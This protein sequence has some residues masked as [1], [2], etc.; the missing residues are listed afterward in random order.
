MMKMIG[1]WKPHTCSFFFC[2][3]C[4]FSQLLLSFHHHIGSPF[5]VMHVSSGSRGFSEWAVDKYP[6][7]PPLRSWKAWNEK[8]TS[9][10]FPWIPVKWAP[11]CVVLSLLDVDWLHVC[12]SDPPPVNGGSR[13]ATPHVTT[14]LSSLLTFS[15]CTELIEHIPSRMALVALSRSPWIKGVEAR[16][17]A[18]RG[19]EGPAAPSA[20]H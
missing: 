18:R 4:P 8:H 1:W 11:V 10:H 2:A 19:S 16:S 9:S 3:V 17:Y 13:C 15:C 12:T 20:G 5:A 6:S 14:A 7:V